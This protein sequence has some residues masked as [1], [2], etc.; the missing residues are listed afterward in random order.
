MLGTYTYRSLTFTGKEIVWLISWLIMGLLM[1]VQYGGS[2]CL[3]LYGISFLK[4]SLFSLGFDFLFISEFCF[5]LLDCSCM[6]TVSCLLLAIVPYCFSWLGSV[7]SVIVLSWQGFGLVPLAMY[8]FN[9]LI[10]FGTG[11]G[12]EPPSLAGFQTP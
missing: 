1:K 4:M 6:A 10:N 12:A 3:L 2:L 11:R 9:G 7:F 8:F 5:I